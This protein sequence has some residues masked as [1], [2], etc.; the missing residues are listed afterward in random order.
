MKTG[1][2]SSS[3]PAPRA[4]NNGKCYHPDCGGKPVIFCPYGGNHPR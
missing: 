2:S 1:E 3:S 4:A